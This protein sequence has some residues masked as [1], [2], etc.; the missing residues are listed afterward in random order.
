MKRIAILMLAALSSGVFAKHN[1]HPV[2]EQLQDDA[3]HTGYSNTT[4]DPALVKK[5][6]IKDFPA[7]EN[8]SSLLSRTVATD[9]AIYL[10]N[11]LWTTS[12]N[13]KKELMALAPE[14]GKFYGK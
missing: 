9:N 12:D 5:L 11:R 7:S 13:Y 8:T 4:I 2:W 14:N 10:Y 3:A 6:W 1:S